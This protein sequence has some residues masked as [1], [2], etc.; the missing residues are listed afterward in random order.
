MKVFFDKYTESVKEMQDTMKQLGVD[1][2]IVVLE[3]NGFLPE[4]INT[5]SMYFVLKK[6]EERHNEKELFYDFLEV[7]EFWEIQPMENKGR[8]CDMGIER[9]IIYFIEPNEK[10]IVQRVEWHMEDGWVYKV[11]FYNKYGL[12][13]ASEFRDRD[14]N[15]ESKVFYSDRNQEVIVEQPQNSVLSL[16]ENGMVEAFFYSYK[17][18]VDFYMEK[19]G[20][21]GKN[22]LFM[23]NEEQNKLLDWNI[24]GKS[25][26]DYVLFLNKELMEKYASGMEQEKSI[27]YAIPE[28]YPQNH[29]TGNAMI[30]TDS[31]QIEKVEELIEDL[32]GVVFHIAAHT[33]VSD[34]LYKLN[35]RENVRVYPGID[36]GELDELWG[37]CDLYL[38]IN[39]YREVDDAV[40]EAHKRNLL[41]MGFE[42]TLHKQDLLINECVFPAG[43][44]GKMALEIKWLMDNPEKMQELLK[45]QQE[46]R[47]KMWNDILQTLGEVEK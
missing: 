47:R 45:I 33:E 44:Y 41:I 28:R 2:E 37:K 22:I 4:G 31:D 13:Y 34:K 36:Y 1:I 6:N 29:V 24:K 7:P 15:V 21:I 43:D 12:N 39:F 42:N 8:I 40:N 30:L 3:D 9:A 35:E 10:R 23:Q 20:I 11:D 27:F 38:D 17:E 32:P 5:P 26:W 14:G 16:L 25:V 19:A 46:K 18:F